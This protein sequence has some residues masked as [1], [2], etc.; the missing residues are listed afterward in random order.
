MRALCDL[1]ERCHGFSGSQRLRVGISR[2]KEV[3]SARGIAQE[4]IRYINIYVR[5][6]VCSGSKLEN[7][8]EN[9]P[10]CYI[11]SEWRNN[12]TVLSRIMREKYPGI[13]F[14]Q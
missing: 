1:S 4:C 5:K 10:K 8:K 11:S 13:K 2:G 14:R 7:E 9:S 3:I 12:S 6:Y